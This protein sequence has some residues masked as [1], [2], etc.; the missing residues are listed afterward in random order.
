MRLDVVLILLGSAALLTAAVSIIW[1]EAKPG[2]KSRKEHEPENEENAKHQNPRRE[3]PHPG[4]RRGSLRGGSSV[5]D[6]VTED[7]YMGDDAETRDA[8]S[9]IR[10]MVDES[11]ER[12]LKILREWLKE[13]EERSV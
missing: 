4:P 9:F 8:E 7:G 10:T 1:R 11:P 6:V 3:M 13:D 12:V 2:D 5:A